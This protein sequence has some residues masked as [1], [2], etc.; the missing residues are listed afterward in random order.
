MGHPNYGTIFKNEHIEIG[1][2]RKHSQRIGK[3]FHEFPK[4]EGITLTYMVHFFLL[5]KQR[6]MI[7]IYF[8]N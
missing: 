7:G 4:D 6:F 3:A 2:P 8:I 1:H 5:Q